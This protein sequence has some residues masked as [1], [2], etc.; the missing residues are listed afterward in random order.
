MYLFHDYI[1]VMG[2]L[3]CLYIWVSMGIW[4]SNRNIQWSQHSGATEKGGHGTSS[5]AYS[6]GRG[7]AWYSNTGDVSYGPGQGRE[8]DVV[9]QDIVL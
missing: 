3:Q 6:F 1:L 8:R 2:L 5:R 9:M 7:H 4:T